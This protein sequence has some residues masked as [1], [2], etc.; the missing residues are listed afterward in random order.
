MKFMIKIQFSLKLLLEFP[1]PDVYD[2]DLNGIFKCFCI[3]N[4]SK[5]LSG[6]CFIRLPPNNKISFL[7]FCYVENL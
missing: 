5:I 4:I 1:W 2:E 3:N 6:F 7:L